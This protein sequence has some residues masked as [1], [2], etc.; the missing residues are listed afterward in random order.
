MSTPSS[1]AA[2]PEPSLREFLLILRQALL[3]VVT[4]IERRYLPAE[5]AARQEWKQI[6]RRRAA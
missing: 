4:W 3:L 2:P 1:D 5:Y 6:R